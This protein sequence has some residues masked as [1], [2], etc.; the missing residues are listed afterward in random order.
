[1]VSYLGIETSCDETAAAVVQDGRRVLSNCLISQI[2]THQ[3]FGG[4]VPE[5]AAREHLE[6]INQVIDQALKDASITAKQLD[7][8]ACTTGPGLIGTLLVGLSAAQALSWSWDLPL[9]G[10]D[11]LMAHVCAN[12]LDTELAPPFVALLVSGGHTQILYF[13]NFACAKL[14]GQ[15]IDD[16]AGEA[17]D[18]V[19]RLLGLDYPGGPIIDKLA[20]DGN[21]QAFKFPQGVVKGFNFSFS[22]LKT[23]VM[24]C[25]EKLEK[26]W[27]VADLAASFQQ[28]VVEVLIRKTLAAQ[29]QT[30]A[31]S[32]VLAGGVAA[33]AALRRK[34]K[35][36]SSVP[37]F[38]PPL[39]LCTDNAAMVASAAYFCSTQKQEPLTAYSRSRPKAIS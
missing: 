16:A 34:F 29:K 32:I 23:S 38:F 30:A 1:M 13:E 12:Y 27:P 33:N 26:P 2:E 7:G 39:H 18:K 24:R 19:A 8:I 10:V 17:Y 15:T 14:L 36:E 35:E 20:S 28:A 11:H 9:I 22:G 3:S 6:T 21:P 5:V 37:V 4:V 25:L 31:Q